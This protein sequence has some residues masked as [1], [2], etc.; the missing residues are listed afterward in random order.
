MK[1]AFIMAEKARFPVQVLCRTLGVSRPGFYASQ[2]RPVA[3]RVREGVQL[4]AEIAAIH[5]ETFE[6]EIAPGTVM[7]VAKQAVVRMIEPTDAD[8]SAES[9]AAPVDDNTAPDQDR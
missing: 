6:V 1:F 9:P 7:K 5:D 8:S 4:G 3:A 2:T